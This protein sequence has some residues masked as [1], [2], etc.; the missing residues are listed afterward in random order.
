MS[1]G[2]QDRGVGQEGYTLLELLL[3]LTVLGTLFLLLVPNVNGLY[4]RYELDAA[5]RLIASDLR[6]AQVASWAH[7]DLHELWFNKFEPQYRLWEDGKSTGQVQLSS[8]VRYRNGYLEN[9]VSLLRFYPN[10]MVAGSGNI[11][12][13]N[14]QKER[15]DLVVYPSS[16]QVVYEGVKR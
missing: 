13:T 9:G 6:A 15:A 1:G 2:V 4:Q 10:G 11:R 3:V 12:L 16:G 8:R 5:S 14:R 7:Q